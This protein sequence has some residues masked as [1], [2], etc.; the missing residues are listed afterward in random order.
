[1]A[2]SVNTPNIGN[3]GQNAAVVRENGGLPAWKSLYQTAILE[4]DTSMIIGRIAEAERAIVERA[5]AL[6]KEPA[7]EHAKELGAL[8]YSAN[9]LAELRLLETTRSAG[10]PCLDVAQT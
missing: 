6:H 1:M 8:A 3:D 9:F 7:S 4:M 2:D 10:K 5:L